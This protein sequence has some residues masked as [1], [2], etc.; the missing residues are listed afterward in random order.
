VQALIQQVKNGFTGEIV[1]DKAPVEGHEKSNGE[2]E[3]AGRLVG[4]LARTLK[5]F[6]EISSEAKLPANHPM[7]V[8]ALVYAAV[9]YPLFHRDKDDGMTA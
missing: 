4:R 2:V 8:W 7:V 5:E 6:V 1:P 9:L 3:R